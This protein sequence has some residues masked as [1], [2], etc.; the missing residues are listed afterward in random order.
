[1]VVQGVEAEEIENFF[2]RLGVMLLDAY[3]ERR[4]SLDVGD[5]L[6]GYRRISLIAPP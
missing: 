5:Q 2:G 4:D 1:V 6:K 3:V